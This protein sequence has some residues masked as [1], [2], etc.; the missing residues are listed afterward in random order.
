MND[1]E[2]QW[3]LVIDNNSGTYSPD[4]GMLHVLKGFLEFNFPGLQV[5]THDFNDQ[6]LKDSRE[7]LHTY[8]RERRGIRESEFTAHPK[9]G[10]TTLMNMA[11]KMGVKSPAE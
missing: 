10:E 2:H 3:Q 1:D 8:A 7:A 5:V 9:M 6:E 11:A 4:K